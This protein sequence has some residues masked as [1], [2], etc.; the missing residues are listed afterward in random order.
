VGLVA[1]DLRRYRK[2]SRVTKT[3]QISITVKAMRGLY[4]LLIRR[5]GVFDAH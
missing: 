3:K 5:I 2:K 1:P 4:I